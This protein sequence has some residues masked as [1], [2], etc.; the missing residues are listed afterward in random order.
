MLKD[1]V[2]LGEK[3]LC[4]LKKGAYKKYSMKSFPWETI[5]RDFNLTFHNDLPW[6]M[7]A[8]FTL[9]AHVAIFIDSM[10]SDITIFL[11]QV[12]YH[13]IAITLPEIG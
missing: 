1:K 2:K 4:D 11:I 9:P 8:M 5:L 7:A 6:P 3:T 10:Y 13:T 12:S